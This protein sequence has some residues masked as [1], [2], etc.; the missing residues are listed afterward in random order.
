MK[1][2]LQDFLHNQTKAMDRSIEK[3]VHVM[4]RQSSRRDRE[5]DWDKNR[6]RDRDR[7]AGYRGSYRNY[8]DQSDHL[9]GIDIQDRLVDHLDIGIIEETEI[10]IEMGIEIELIGEIEVHQMKVM[11]GQDLEVVQ[12]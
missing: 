1:D 6:S 11:K 12:E 2:D 9:V 7:N 8:R 4:D 3:L 5:K 10:E